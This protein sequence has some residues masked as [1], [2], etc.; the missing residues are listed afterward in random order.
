MNFK[1]RTDASGYL[2]SCGIKCSAETLAKFASVGGGPEM[3]KFGGQVLYTTDALDRGPLC[4]DAY[5]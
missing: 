1:T 3:V 4:Y 5:A 2:G